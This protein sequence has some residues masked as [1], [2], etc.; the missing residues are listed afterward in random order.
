MDNEIKYLLNHYH[1]IFSL[2]NDL[3]D[4]EECREILC[5]TY[6]PSEQDGN[7]FSE[8]AKTLGFPE[9]MSKDKYNEFI[10]A[11]EN[12]QGECPILAKGECF[13]MKFDSEEI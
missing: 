2:G 7:K 5:N 1:G 11:T 13:T 10:K 4:N 8:E 6:S 3:F 9:K 12:L